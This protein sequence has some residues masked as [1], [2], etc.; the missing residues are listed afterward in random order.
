MAVVGVKHPSLV[1]NVVKPS[2]FPLLH[3]HYCKQVIAVED[4]TV[5][6]VGVCVL[7]ACVVLR[8]Y[9]WAE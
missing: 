7:I 5:C 6:V 2:S 8:L 3:L 4:V 9:H 1:H